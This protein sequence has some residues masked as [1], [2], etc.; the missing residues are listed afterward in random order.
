MGLIPAAIPA[1]P[2]Q[3]GIALPYTPPSLTSLAPQIVRSSV[4]GQKSLS[5]GFDE[6]GCLGATD[7]RDAKSQFCSHG[8]RVS[9]SCILNSVFEVL[10][11]AS[12]RSTVHVSTG[13]FVIL[14]TSRMFLLCSKSSLV[15][16][17]W[18]M[19]IFPVAAFQRQKKSFE[20]IGSVLPA[21]HMICHFCASSVRL[22]LTVECKLQAKTC[23]L[24]MYDLWRNGHTTLLWSTEIMI[25]Y[26]HESNHG[27]LV[28]KIYK[29]CS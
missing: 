2:A 10:R 25:L 19:R 29:S 8:P 21:C 14:N 1:T 16:V 26:I 22:T 28:I 5:A 17:Y 6:V 18:S 4:I 11:P 27:R 7:R 24:C 3:N 23:R 15:C 9:S 13:S 20:A 12:T